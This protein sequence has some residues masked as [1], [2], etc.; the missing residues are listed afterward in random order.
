MQYSKIEKF[1]IRKI[2]QSTIQ[3]R[4]MQYSKMEKFKIRKIQ[5]SKIQKSENANI[6]KLKNSKFE[7][8]KS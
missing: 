5:K 8:F 3:D 6:Q 2:Q 4:K 7:I 1:K